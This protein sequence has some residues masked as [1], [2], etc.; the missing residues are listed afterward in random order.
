LS[1]CGIKK[2]RYQSDLISR[3]YYLDKRLSTVYFP[4]KSLLIIMS[5]ISKDDLR[6]EIDGILEGADLD[7]LSSKKVRQQLEEKLKFDLTDRKKEIDELVMEAVEN[8]PQKDDDAEK[9]KKVADDSG[10]EDAAEKN[11]EPPKKKAKA[12]KSDESGE[13]DDE[14]EAESAEEKGEEEE[15]EEEEDEYQPDDDEDSP[16]KKG[17]QGSRQSSRKPAADEPKP[18]GR[19]SRS[20]LKKKSMAEN[21]NSESEEKSESEESED[22]DAAP[23]PPPAKKRGPKPGAKAARKDDAPKSKVV[24][25]EYSD[26]E[27]EEFDADS[28]NSSDG[29]SD[30]EYSPGKKSPGKKKGARGGRGAPGRK[31]RMDSSDPD[32]SDEDWKKATKRKRGP[33]AKK[34]EG[35]PK[36][37]ANKTVKLSAELSDIMG[38][39]SM[40]RPEVVKKMWS[41][42]KER[43]LYDPKNKQFAVCDEQLQKVFGV[44][45][46]RTF[47]MMKYL[48]SHFTD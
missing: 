21:S 19:P 39:D 31:K 20:D 48:K 5:V 45:R 28:T 24:A 35:T 4:H 30:E 27:F 15:E 23:P 46:F 38:V 3:T 11:K 7:T 36:P 47:G 44:K 29:G 25:K 34:G 2:K 22:S 6:K 14:K 40:P 26:S 1:V 10:D 9:P 32:D 37:K 13:E 43:N 18:K 8:K 17:R 33:P 42:I 41:I 12:S 16:K